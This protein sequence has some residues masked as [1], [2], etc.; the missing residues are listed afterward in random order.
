ML[1]PRPTARRLLTTALVP[2]VAGLAACG[3]DGLEPK[4]F[5]IVATD[6][7]F[8]G[9]PDEAAAGSTLTLSNESTAEVHELVAIRLPEDEERAADELVALPMPELMAFTAGLTGVTVAPPAADGFVV[10]G[11][12]ELTEPGRYLILCAIPTGV[13]PGEYLAAAQASQGGPPE[14]DGAGPPHFVQGMYAE[15]TVVA[16]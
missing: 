15:L 6:Y 8:E 7:A 1:I 2:L 14:I 9:L 11:S 5:A 16:G 4:D 10:E 13:D 12:G 3:D